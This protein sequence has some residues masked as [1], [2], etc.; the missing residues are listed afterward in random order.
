MRKPCAI[1][2]LESENWTLVAFDYTEDA[3]REIDRFFKDDHA[4]IVPLTVQEI[5]D[6]QIARKLA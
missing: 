3:L 1:P 6:E 5:L 4:V 2:P